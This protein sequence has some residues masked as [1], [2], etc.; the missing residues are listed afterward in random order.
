MF[1]VGVVRKTIVACYFALH[2][3]FCAP[4]VRAQEDV[5]TRAMRD[6]LDRSM[7]TLQ[8]EKLE[9]P[10]FLAYRTQDLTITNVSATLG[11]LRNSNIS[12]SRSLTV[13]MRVGDYALDNT[14]FTSAP[15]FAGIS[16]AFPLPLED[17]YKELRRQI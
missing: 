14:N 12:H 16:R 8:L 10:Y 2:V 5:V 1:S 9:R 3:L 13:D 6:E 7:K 15:G 4:W 17:N 11:S